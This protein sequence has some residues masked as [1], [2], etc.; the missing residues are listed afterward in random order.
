MFNNIK[1]P[2]TQSDIIFF[3]VDARNG[4]TTTDFKIRDWINENVVQTDFFEKNEDGELVGDQGT[5]RK[6][7]KIYVKRVVLIAN[8]CDEGETFGAENELYQLGLGEPIYIAVE[9]GEGMHELW[10]EIDRSVPE[11]SQ[12]WFKERAK[13][14]KSRYKKLRN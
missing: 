9:S 7:D 8:K 3:I 4:I 2:L 13:K 12:L 10:G 11:E 6:D 1:E 14:R 5:G